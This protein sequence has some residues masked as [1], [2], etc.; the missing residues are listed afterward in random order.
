V[1]R[2]HLSKVPP[3]PHHPWR[4]AS[5]HGPVPLADHTANYLRV[6]GMLL[7]CTGHPHQSNPH[8]LH[9]SPL[10]TASSLDSALHLSLSFN[11]PSLT[12]PKS[13]FCRLYSLRLPRRRHPSVPPPAAFH[14]YD[15]GGTFLTRALSL[16]RFYPAI[17]PQVTCITGLPLAPTTYYRAHSGRRRRANTANTAN[18]ERST[19]V[20]P[21]P[22]F[23]AL[24][25]NSYLEPSRPTA[26]DLPK[27]LLVTTA[28]ST[29]RRAPW[30]PC[31]PVYLEATPLAAVAVPRSVFCWFKA[32][33][34]R[35]IFVKPSP[36]LAK[37][38]LTL[39]P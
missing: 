12:Q 31:P 23:P 17:S 1:K 9:N 3:P 32:D 33:T 5:W 13:L 6:L 11:P 4:G 14:Y 2:P 21:S 38:P 8:P 29:T 28:L 7:P 25:L 35:Y 34:T 10:P 24:P 22:V 26:P 19:P 18:S 39:D 27:W 15:P 20:D 16:R 37:H 30:S 36:G